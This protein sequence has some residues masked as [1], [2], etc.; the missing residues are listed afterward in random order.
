MNTDKA[1]NQYSRKHVVPSSIIE[2][3]QLVLRGFCLLAI[4]ICGAFLLSSIMVI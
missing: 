1:I 4:P 3:V 2:L